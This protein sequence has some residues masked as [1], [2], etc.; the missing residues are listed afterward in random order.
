MNYRC[1]KFYKKQNTVN[2]TVFP[3]FFLLRFAPLPFL[4]VCPSFLQFF[5]LFFGS[6]LL[7]FFS[8]SLVFDRIPPT[9]DTAFAPFPRFHL[10]VCIS[11][12]ICSSVP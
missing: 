12:M 10:A 1:K 2:I 6:F 7:F 8:S 5:V 4:S 11:Y 9:L 3:S